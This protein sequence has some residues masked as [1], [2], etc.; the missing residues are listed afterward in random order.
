M[1]QPKYLSKEAVEC[2]NKFAK[3]EKNWYICR[4]CNYVMLAVHIDQG[5]TPFF[6]ECK[7]CGNN[8][9]STMYSPPFPEAQDMV[10]P[11]IE[12]Y[13]P[14]DEEFAKF[15][16]EWKGHY[17][18]GGLRDRLT[19]YK[20]PKKTADDEYS[21]F[22]KGLVE[23]EDGSINKEALKKELSDYTMIIDHCTKA[24]YHMTEGEVSNPLTLPDEIKNIA[25]NKASMRT[26]AAIEESVKPLL[27]L[28]RGFYH[29]AIVGDGTHY[30]SLQEEEMQK[31]IKP[32][33]HLPIEL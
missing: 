33:S 13:R 8:S 2:I 24:Y 27:K 19:V 10:D 28:V 32:F 14:S 16:E 5:V 3:Q 18:Q 12:W 29:D 1:T 11:E 23:N 7:S 4:S 15:P 25:N 31:A 22:W 17:E 6:M 21:E 30:S 9:H 26:L 20:D